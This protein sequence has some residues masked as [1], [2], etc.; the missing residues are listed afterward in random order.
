MIKVPHLEWHAAH[1]C[2]FTCESCTHYSNHG[3]NKVVSYL[4]LKKWL[5]NWNKR[6][7]PLR[8]AV[9]GGEP[10]INKEILDIIYLG[11]EMWNEGNN[12]Y[13]IVTNGFLLH[14]YP[15]LPKVLKETNCVL[16]I[17]I[18]GNTPEYN[19][20]IDEVKNLVNEWIKEFGIKVNPIDYSI[21][22]LRTYRGFGDQIEP[23]EDNNYQKSW[24]NCP[25]G[26]ECFQLF[27]EC[28]YKCSSLAYLPLLEEKFKLSHKWDMY[29][30]YKPLSPNCSDNQ[31][32]EFFQKQ[33]E[34]YCSMCPSKLETFEKN[35]PLIPIKFYKFNK[36]K[37]SI[38]YV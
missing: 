16:S 19:K 21:N 4:T 23:Y 11:R 37:K 35:D 34:S 38:F 28:L 6:I 13:E 7:V 15:D 33:A 10:L 29:L 26:Q 31:I 22:W 27:E 1:A 14:K 3:I 9:L 2:N 24:D 25:S 32:V 18:H 36:I 5:L 8:M 17:S 12:Y 30:K 20:R